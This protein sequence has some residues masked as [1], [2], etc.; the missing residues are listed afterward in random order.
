MNKTVILFISIIFLCNHVVAKDVVDTKKARILSLANK[1]LNDA[2]QCLLKLNREGHRPDYFRSLEDARTNLK[3]AIIAADNDANSEDKINEVRFTM[4]ITRAKVKEFMEPFQYKVQQLLANVRTFTILSNQLIFSHSKDKK[5]VED[6]KQ[7]LNK[8]YALRDKLLAA[9]T[10]TE[11]YD[12]GIQL[13]EAE[14]AYEKKMFEFIHSPKRNSSPNILSIYL[15]FVT[16]FLSIIF[17][18]V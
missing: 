8:I 17:R 9:V 18:F 16:V 6:M 1:V 13:A 5:F 3:N 14:E 11:K 7:E 2:E 10:N 15:M 4:V 12:Y